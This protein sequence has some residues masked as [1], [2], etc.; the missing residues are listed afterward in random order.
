MCAGQ[1]KQSRLQQLVDW[2]GGAHFDGC[3]IF[4]ECHKAKHFI[5][6]SHSG[7]HLQFYTS[8]RTKQIIVKLCCSV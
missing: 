6:V 1:V 3:L 4:D 2:C 8:V 5:P 7:W